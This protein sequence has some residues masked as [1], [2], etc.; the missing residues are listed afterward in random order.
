MLIATKDAVPRK[1]WE[2]QTD[3]QAFQKRPSSEQA[4]DSEHT[5]R[6]QRFCFLIW[7]LAAAFAIAPLHSQTPA[8]N[9]SATAPTIKVETRVVLLDVVVTDNKGEPVTGLNNRDF[10]VTEEGVLRRT[11]NRATGP[12]QTSG[13]AGQRLYEL[14]QHEIRGLRQRPLARLVEHAAVRPSLRAPASDQL[15]EQCPA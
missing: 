15:S 4:P 9:P 7:P 13:N 12:D 1:Q 11:Q 6:S 14:S 3:V 10:Q 2:T 5:M 8:S